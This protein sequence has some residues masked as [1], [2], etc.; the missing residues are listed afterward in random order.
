MAKKELKKSKKAGQKTASLAVHAEQAI[1]DYE[2]A[3]DLF[4]RKRLSEAA[5][6][7]KA[8]LRDHPHEKE[9]GDRCRAYLRISERETESKDLPLKRADDYYYQAVVESNR[10]QYDEAIKHLDQALKLEP[11]DDRLHYALASTQSLRGDRDQAL[12]ALKAAIELN[13]VNRIHAR[14]DPD[15]EPLRDDDAFI[16]MVMIRKE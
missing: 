9:I 13:A 15:F 1:Q 4:Q 2:R 6:A 10:Q 3:L 14:Q 7:F 16:D 11:R 5:D 12:S 8:F